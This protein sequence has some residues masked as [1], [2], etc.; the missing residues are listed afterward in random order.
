MEWLLR[1]VG[2]FF[3]WL[4]SLMPDAPYARFLLGTLL[5]AGAVIIVMLIMKRLRHGR[6]QSLWRRKAK[7]HFA[8]GDELEWQP[9]VVPVHAWLDEADT[10][11][12]EGRFAEAVHCLLLRSVA[13][14]TKR[15]PQQVSP[16]LTS[17]ELA[18]STIL[19][20]RARAL[21][22]G[23]AQSVERSLFGGQSVDSLEWTQARAAY[24]EF[25]LARAWKR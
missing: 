18:R 25:T 13:D 8:D 7:Q 12:S 16:A 19:P 23:I 1:P 17:R 3:A 5:V 24:A 22:A 15:R 4:L 6:W 20:E 2:R 14:A 9:D 21:F 11:A 10:L